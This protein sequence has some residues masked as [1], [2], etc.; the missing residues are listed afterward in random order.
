M[1][2]LAFLFAALAALWIVAYWPT[3][4][5]GPWAA[6]DTARYELAK[7]DAHR[8][9]AHLY[10]YEPDM[11]DWTLN[12]IENVDEALAHGQPRQ[13]DIDDATE[14]II[15]GTDYVERAR[16]E[17][18]LEYGAKLVNLVND[19]GT[20][21]EAA[22]DQVSGG[23]ASFRIG[24]CGDEALACVYKDATVVV[25]ADFAFLT[26]DELLD[27]GLTARWIDVMRHEY[28]HVLQNKLGERL[29]RDPEYLRLFDVVPVGG[30]EYPDADWA[31]ESSA[32]CMAETM[33]IVYVP[34]YPGVCVGERGEFARWMLD[35]ALLAD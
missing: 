2:S 13:E 18:Q 16:A 30:E 8:V 17:W 28:M 3:S 21:A 6:P 9:L 29:A 14:K 31:Y 15:A 4:P 22:L 12:I 25:T 1:R 26:D 32:D 33:D 35:E 34:L 27:E 24:D 11:R 19:S 20:D 23:A 7:A 10:G 5:Y